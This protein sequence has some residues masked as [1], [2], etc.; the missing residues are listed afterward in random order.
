MLG[1]LAPASFGQSYLPRSQNGHFDSGLTNWNVTGSVSVLDAGTDFD[2]VRLNG[3]SSLWQYQPATTLTKY[4]VLNCQA[5]KQLRPERTGQP[6]WAGI[7]ISYYDSQWGFIQTFEKQINVPTGLD[8]FDEPALLP[9]TLGV[10]VPPNAVHSIIWIS[11]DGANTETIA[12]ALYLFDY[13]DRPQTILT[14]PTTEAWPIEDVNGQIHFISGLQF[15]NIN[16][17]FIDV[18]NGTIGTAG[19]PSSVSQELRNVQPGTSLQFRVY[20]YA[21]RASDAVPA[22]VGVDYFDVNWQRIGGTSEFLNSAP[23]FDSFTDLNVTIP[24]GAAH[25][26]FWIWVDA[27]PDNVSNQHLRT[28][29]ISTQLNDTV[30]PTATIA[31]RIANRGIN[32]RGFKFSLNYVDNVVSYVYPDPAGVTLIGPTGKVFPF[33]YPQIVTNAQNPK[34]SLIRWEAYDPDNTSV[35]INWSLEPVGTYTLTVTTEAVRDAAG[36][37]LAAPITV[38]FQ[39]V[40]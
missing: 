24:T 13:F 10:N 32:S 17:G 26:I 20:H 36:N 34:R 19:L 6:G 31:G 15:W 14:N 25:S 21:G 37:P 22:N 16:G 12:D 2:K 35:P 9:C 8:E 30:K 1:Y 33:L 18:G 40:R 27:L 3:V 28:I 23:N 11:N 7:G 4:Q 5:I 39:N 29:Y 38:T